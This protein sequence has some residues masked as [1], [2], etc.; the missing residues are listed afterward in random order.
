MIWSSVTVLNTISMLILQ[1]CKLVSS[2]EL[3]CWTPDS[4]IQLRTWY[5]N[6]DVYHPN[7]QINLLKTN[8]IKSENLVPP[9][10]SPYVLPA[11]LVVFPSQN[12]AI[13]FLAPQIKF[14]SVILNFSFSLIPPIYCIIKFCQLTLLYLSRILPLLTT[15]MASTLAQLHPHILSRLLD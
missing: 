4:F 3:D 15:F 11:S 5:L 1:K 2:M 12:K 9:Q 14:F 6:L 8:L 7:L 13:Y 10:C